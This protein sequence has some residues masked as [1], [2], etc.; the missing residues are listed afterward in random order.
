MQGNA[1]EKAEEKEAEEGNK[2]GNPKTE[3]K[4]IRKYTAALVPHSAKEKTQLRSTDSGS[5]FPTSFGCAQKR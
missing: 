3:K 5:G 4:K 2:E 1:Y